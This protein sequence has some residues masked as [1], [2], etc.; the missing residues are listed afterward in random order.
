MS[1]RGCSA[2]LITKVDETLSRLYTPQLQDKVQSILS[3]LYVPSNQNNHYWRPVLHSSAPV[4][5]IL[6]K[7]GISDYCNSNLCNAVRKSLPDWD[8]THDKVYTRVLGGDS[9]SNNLENGDFFADQRKNIGV[10][11]YALHIFMF[12]V[13]DSRKVP[14]FVSVPVPAVST[15]LNGKLFTYSHAQR[16]ELDNPVL[17]KARTKD[18]NAETVFEVRPF[19]IYHRR[20]ARYHLYAGMKCQVRNSQVKHSCLNPFKRNVYLVQSR[21][22]VFPS[23]AG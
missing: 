21:S 10:D 16:R 3:Q 12:A 4:H 17:H 15:E 9:S 19:K 6:C 20:V 23:Y 13:S 22:E 18:V 14:F 5:D 1:T 11:K 2:S 7:F 8:I